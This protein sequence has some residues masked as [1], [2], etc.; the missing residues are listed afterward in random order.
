[1]I[2]GLEEMPKVDGGLVALGIALVTFIAWLSR[3]ESKVGNSE[4]DI[5]KL[6]KRQIVA[7]KKTED[8]DT[9]VDGQALHHR[10]DGRQHPRS[11]Q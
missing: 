5:E 3:L 4:R 2:I 6:E 7:D 10:E 8:L 11:A 1:M 9:R